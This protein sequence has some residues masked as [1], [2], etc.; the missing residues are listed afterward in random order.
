MTRRMALE[1]CAIL[2]AMGALAG[3]V[4]AQFIPRQFRSQTT[5]AFG[6]G[7]TGRYAEAASQTMSTEA[8]RPV[9][10]QSA[11][12]KSELDYTPVDEVIERIQ[13]NASIRSVEGRNAFHIEFTDPDRYAAL[14]VTRVLAEQLAHNAG[15]ATRVLEAIRAG[16]TGPGLGLCTS[17]GAAAGLLIGLIV[18]VVAWRSQTD[19]S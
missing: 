4:T 2:A 10:L 5:V 19:I 17:L 1:V 9:I 8:L 6:G 12:Y 7:A 16:P 11:Y 18:V 13:A 3:F 14:D 15:E